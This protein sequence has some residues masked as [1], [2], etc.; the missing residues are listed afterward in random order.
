VFLRNAR[1]AGIEPHGRNDVPE[2][3]GL[4]PFPS[5]HLL[6][7]PI[8]RVGLDLIQIAHPLRVGLVRWQLPLDDFS[9]L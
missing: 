9:D 5:N 7:D 2:L 8:A 4:E 6:F 1:N 3:H